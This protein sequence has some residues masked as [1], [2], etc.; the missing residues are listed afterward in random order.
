MRRTVTFSILI[1]LIGFI[2]MQTDTAK[3]VIAQGCRCQEPYPPC[4]WT[5]GTWDSVNCTCV[6]GCPL[7]IDLN[8]DGYDLTDAASGLNSPT[9]KPQ[10]GYSGGFLLHCSLLAEPGLH[11]LH[12]RL[13]SPLNHRRVLLVLRF[14]NSERH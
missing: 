12:R 11:E 6:F 8:H 4:S 9:T 7:I 2:A 1:M 5:G 14:S 10:S 13:S 3:P